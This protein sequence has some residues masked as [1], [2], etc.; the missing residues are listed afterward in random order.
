[1]TDND[2]LA[3]ALLITLAPDLGERGRLVLSLLFGLLVILVN[4]S[5]HYA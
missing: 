1:M 3:L 5:K 2:F 4:V